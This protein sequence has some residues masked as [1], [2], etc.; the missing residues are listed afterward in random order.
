MDENILREAVKLAE[1]WR[2]NN[3]GN[4][5]AP[6]VAS[7]SIKHALKPVLAALASQLISQ[8]DAMDAYHVQSFPGFTAVKYGHPVAPGD[9]MSAAYGPNRDE[10]SIIAC[11]EFLRGLK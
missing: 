4:I 8:V 5:D 3:A 6:C 9:D 10:N 2:I 1:G 7:C 11:V